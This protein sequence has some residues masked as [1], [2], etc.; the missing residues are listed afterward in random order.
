MRVCFR[1][2]SG[3]ILQLALVTGIRCFVDFHA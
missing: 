3:A 1:A 2:E